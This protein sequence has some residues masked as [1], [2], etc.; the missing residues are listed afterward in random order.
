MKVIFAILWFYF[1]TVL[2]FI[3]Y[4]PYWL[5]MFLD[6]ANKNLKK[7]IRLKN[8]KLTKT[9]NYGI[10]SFRFKYLQKTER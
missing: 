10:R 1:K 4:Y 6:K 7:P 8:I 5:L 2:D 9:L 3:L